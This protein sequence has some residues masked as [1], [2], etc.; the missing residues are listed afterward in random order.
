MLLSDITE[1][2]TNLNAQYS[3]SRRMG[4]VS[5]HVFTARELYADTYCLVELEGGW[6]NNPFWRGL[7]AGP[8]ETVS[9]Y[10]GYSI[11]SAGP[12][13]VDHTC[14]AQSV[15]FSA[16]AYTRPARLRRL[17]HRRSSTSAPSRSSEISSASP[18][19]SDDP[20]NA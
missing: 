6:A 20:T 16:K 3:D 12:S 8:D 1:H 2:R 19:A 7:Q 9:T 15:R 14:A 4:R 18:V 5:A 11:P 13:T 10:T 17:K